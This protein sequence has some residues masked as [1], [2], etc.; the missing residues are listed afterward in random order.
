MTIFD[1]KV[2]IEMFPANAGDC[3]LIEFEKED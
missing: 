3:I 2:N 1:D